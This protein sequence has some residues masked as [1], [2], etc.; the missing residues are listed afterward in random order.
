MC[1][2]HWGTQ[3][4][5]QHSTARPAAA[6]ELQPTHR[7]TAACL[8]LQQ[9]GVGVS[10]AK[11]R[12][13]LTYVP[14]DAWQ[15]EPTQVRSRLQPVRVSRGNLAWAGWCQPIKPLQPQAL[16]NDLPPPLPRTRAVRPIPTTLIA[17]VAQ[18]A[19]LGAA[20]GAVR[21]RPP[22]GSRDKQPLYTWHI[23]LYSTPDLRYCR[24]RVIIALP[25]TACSDSRWYLQ[26]THR[27]P[28]FR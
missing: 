7:P 2:L 26:C 18:Q 20:G 23:E 16:R 4:A 17:T 13:H 6:A 12:S 1:G 24:P 15:Y 27:Q 8:F 19:H 28:G 14:L 5:A 3:G 10:A 25:G 22:A 11:A 21:R 9:G